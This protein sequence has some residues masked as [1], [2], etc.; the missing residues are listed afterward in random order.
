MS[1]AQSTDRVYTL[2]IA[3][4]KREEELEGEIDGLRMGLDGRL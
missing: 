4:L 1:A 2:Q 3:A